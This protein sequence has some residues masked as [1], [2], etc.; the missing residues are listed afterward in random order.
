MWQ[1]QV[2]H[3]FRRRISI[4][5]ISC[6]QI[7]TALKR[8]KLYENEKRRAH[9]YVKLERFIQVLRTIHQFN[10]LPEKVVGQLGEVFQWNQVAFFIREEKDYPCGHLIARKNGRRI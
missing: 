1:A 10:I 4:A 9:Y 2:K 6:F 8:A 7:G 5:S 3:I